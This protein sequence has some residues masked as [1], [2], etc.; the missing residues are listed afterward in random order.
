MD[1]APNQ[2]N[3]R[4]AGKRERLEQ[5]GPHHGDR[6]DADRDEDEDLKTRM[7]HKFPHGLRAQVP[8]EL[9]LMGRVFLVCSV[10]PH[11]AGLLFLEWNQAS[12]KP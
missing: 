6:I 1:P 9:L 10:D 8:V 11:I 2:K 3:T 5:K 12:T 4:L 7:F